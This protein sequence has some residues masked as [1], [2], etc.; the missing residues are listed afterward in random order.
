MI[1]SSCTDPFSRMMAE[2]IA[3][4]DQ[5]HNSDDGQG[6]LIPGKTGKGQPLQVNAPDEFQAK[7]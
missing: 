7:A 1:G 4:K 5:G 3:R 6:Q 2:Q